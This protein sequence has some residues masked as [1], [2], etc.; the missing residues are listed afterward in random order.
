MLNSA[1]AAPVNNLLLY[2]LNAF[3][4]AD[5]VIITGSN[6]LQLLAVL[7]YMHRVGRELTASV[8][9]QQSQS[10]LAVSNRFVFDDNYFMLLNTAAMQLAGLSHCRN[11]CHQLYAVGDV[12]SMEC[13]YQSQENRVTWG[14]LYSQ[15]MCSLFVV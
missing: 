13:R 4:V 12:M 6:S 15:E 3:N 7:P 11:I 9:R 14:P 2:S 8:Q 1:L 10:M 5:R